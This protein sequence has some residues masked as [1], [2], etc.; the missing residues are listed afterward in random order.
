MDGEIG[1]Y[2]VDKVIAWRFMW[3]H[4]L[5]EVDPMWQNEYEFNSFFDIRD[6]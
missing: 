6:Y 3:F 1:N 2:I 4:A 5:S